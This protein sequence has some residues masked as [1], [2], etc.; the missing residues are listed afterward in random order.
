MSAGMGR[1]IELQNCVKKTKEISYL[2][3]SV[4]QRLTCSILAV[5]DQF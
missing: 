3:T 4:V 2:K 1:W 5:R